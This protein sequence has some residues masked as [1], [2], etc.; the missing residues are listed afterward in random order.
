MNQDVVNRYLS[1]VPIELRN[2]VKALSNNNKW[3]VF[4]ALIIEGEKNFTSLKDLFDFH[5]EEL[6]RSLKSLKSGGLIRKYVTS[7]DDVG[8]PNGT[9]YA[10]TDLGRN[11]LDSLYHSLMDRD[12]II[13]WW[14]RTSI[15]MEQEMESTSTAIS[16]Q[17]PQAAFGR[18]EKTGRLN[19]IQRGGVII[20]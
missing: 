14:D 9:F 6:N 3:A 10:P 13:E 4:I 15:R 18:S 1:E 8:K 7:L 2:S 5:P 11:L 19:K 17:F 20:V 12:E 16:K